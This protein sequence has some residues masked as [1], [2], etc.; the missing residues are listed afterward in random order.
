MK[1]LCKVQFE[2]VPIQSLSFS[3]GKDVLYII[4]AFQKGEIPSPPETLY[5]VT[6]DLLDHAVV[7]S[8]AFQL[9]EDGRL[10]HHYVYLFSYVIDYTSLKPVL[11]ETDMVL[12]EHS[13]HFKK[14][15]QLIS[16]GFCYQESSLLAEGF[17][18]ESN[19]VPE[20]FKC[21]GWN[22]FLQ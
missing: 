1:Q 18:F 22:E 17:L 13:R 12:Y 5:F 6:K 10:R 14:A 16:K 7:H 20:R 4:E 19:I 8:V 2:K 9:V 3:F 15:V 21:Y 11:Y